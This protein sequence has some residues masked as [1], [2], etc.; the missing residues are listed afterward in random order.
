M[1][2]PFRHCSGCGTGGLTPR[3][4]REFVCPACGYRHFVTPIPAA[5]AILLDAGNRLLVIRRGHEPGLG[6]LG[7]PGGV[8]EGGE[9]AEVACAREVQEEVGLHV[10]PASFSYVASIPNLYLFQDFVWPT[11][12]LFYLARVE[13]FDQVSPAEAEVLECLALP[14]DQVPLADFA[15]ASNA[16]AVRLMQ[17]LAR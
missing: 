17:K 16:E 5:C 12:D 3:S 6:K 8:I 10:P 11:V 9:T 1:D 13:S 2:H 14:L 7:L 4:G 15:F